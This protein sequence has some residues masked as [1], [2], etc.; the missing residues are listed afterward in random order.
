MVRIMHYWMVSDWVMY[1]W[2]MINA[3]VAMVDV[4]MRAWMVSTWL[5]GRCL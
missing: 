5:L 3:M 1:Y 4:V 2:M